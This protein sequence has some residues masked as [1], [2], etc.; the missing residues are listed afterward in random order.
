MLY[1]GYF[2]SIDTSIDPKGQLY[3]VEI[4]TNFN[5]EVDPYPYGGFN[6]DHPIPLNGQ[7]IVMAANPFTVSYSSDESNIYKSYKCSTATVNILLD[8]LNPDF[9]TGSYNK[10][11]V[12]LL[13]ERH[14]VENLNDSGNGKI[15]GDGRY[16]YRT[17]IRDDDNNLIYNDYK[18]SDI[19]KVCYDVE[20][21]GFVTPN[22]YNQNYTLIKQNFTLECQ[23]ALSTLQYD[24][25]YQPFT[26]FTDYISW[27]NPMI[28]SLGTYNHIYYTDTIKVP[29]DEINSSFKRIVFNPDNFYSETDKKWDNNLSILDSLLSFVNCTMI[30][31]G[32]SVYI[33]NYDGIANDN[34]YY[35]HYELVR[36]SSNYMGT[37]SWGVSRG[38]KIIESHIHLTKDDFN[39]SDTNISIPTVYNKVTLDINENSTD[40][41]ISDISDSKNMYYYTSPGTSEGYAMINYGNTGQG[42]TTTDVYYSRIIDHGFL[43]YPNPNKSTIQ[44]HIYDRATNTEIIYDPEIGIGEASLN[45]SGFQYNYG[46]IIVNNATFESYNVNSDGTSTQTTSHIKTNVKSGV[47]LWDSRT[48]T[49]DYTRT[50]LTIT[51]T[52]N[53][54]KEDSINLK[55]Y[56]E[57]FKPLHPIYNQSI[58][59]ND[60]SVARRDMYLEAK[61]KLTKGSS[62][63][64]FSNLNNT[65][66]GAELSSGNWNNT[67]MWSNTDRKCRLPLYNYDTFDN[68]TLYGKTWN[69][70]H[71]SLAKNSGLV[72]PLP[73]NFSG[74]DEI[75]TVTIEF[76][77][78][79]NLIYT[80]HTLYIGSMLFTNL[81][82]T[83]CKKKNIITWDWDIEASRYITDSE[84][85]QDET[86]IT[87]NLTSTYLNNSKN[88]AFR[89]YDGNYYKLNNIHNTGNSIISTPENLILANY[90]NQYKLPHY[91]ISTSVHYNSGVKPYSHIL[92]DTQFRGVDFV[93]DRMNIDYEYNST[94]LTIVD[95]VVSSELPDIEFEFQGTD[96][97]FKSPNFLNPY[98]GQ[99]TVYDS[100]GYFYQLG[101]RSTIACEY[102]EDYPHETDIISEGTISFEPLFI[103]GDVQGKV[104]IP[105]ITDVEV[106]IDDNGDLIIEN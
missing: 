91:Y 55:G 81:E 46:S 51:K 25:K 27:I 11:L 105:D 65:T 7:E 48:T 30:P 67:T 98:F 47:L 72:I 6:I 38:H 23:D 22:T 64:Y 99:S 50:L 33:V 26:T 4:F 39:G 77:F 100:E 49:R 5:K 21:I 36:S 70:Q 3:K 20:W 62:T 34:Q 17:E 18:P 69:F 68:S 8:R 89:V 97:T 56:V 35:W 60:G 90:Y 43:S 79:N 103:D 61:V 101:M 44:C 2:R 102:Y 92:Y 10:I 96:N 28:A 58:D 59:S 84:G 63:Y 40:N 80:D 88:Y 85:L 106:S 37:P 1:Y 86:T 71:T 13:K 14:D 12:A 16:C 83:T 75:C 104:C 54:E 19:D 87:T 41:I 95:K 24:T 32:D 53:I 93:V 78:K 31:Y 45:D 82:M 57:F 73:I 94:T 42:T 52:I 15:N 76:Y 66:E 9:F 74:T 29:N